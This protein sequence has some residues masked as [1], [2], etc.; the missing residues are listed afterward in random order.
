MSPQAKKQQ[1][2]NGMRKLQS[3]QKKTRG[4]NQDLDQ[5]LLPHNRD[6]G[7]NSATAYSKEGS[8][9]EGLSTQ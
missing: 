9:G 6:R 7:R 4:K 2:N 8:R 1:Y 5:I 3:R